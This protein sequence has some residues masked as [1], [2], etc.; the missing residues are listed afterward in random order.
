[1]NTAVHFDVLLN[2]VTALKRETKLEEEERM[3]SRLA[4]L[5]IEL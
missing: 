5:R 4:V 3:V 1:M 2:H